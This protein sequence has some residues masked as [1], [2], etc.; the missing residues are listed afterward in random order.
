[1]VPVQPLDGSVTVTL[2]VAGI[3]MVLVAVVIPAPQ[4]KP[5]PAALEEAVN[6]S[7]TLTQVRGVGAVI[8]ATGAVI[9]WVTVTE[10]VLLQPL[11]GS[12]TV[13]V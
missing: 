5:E 3:E 10:W 4:L 13:T 9:F 11:A 2:Y 1:M 8:L 7:L 12:V 6:T